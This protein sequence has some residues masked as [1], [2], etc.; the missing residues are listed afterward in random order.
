MLLHMQPAQWV[1]SV[2]TLLL[3]FFPPLSL[4]FHTHIQHYTL[5]VSHRHTEP[6]QGIFITLLNCQKCIPKDISINSNSKL[7][8]PV[9]YNKQAGAVPFM[10]NKMG[11]SLLNSYYLF[12]I[13]YFS[14]WVGE[15]SSDSPLLQDGRS[16]RVTS[17]SLRVSSYNRLL[18]QRRNGGV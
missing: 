12:V 4:T 15:T 1:W 14:Q 9:A 5:L 17:H 10:G 16:Y 6:V 7:V 18:T 13:F 11:T 8:C 2:L 3:L